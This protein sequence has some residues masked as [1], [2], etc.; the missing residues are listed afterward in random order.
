[1]A[2]HTLPIKVR[3]A[4]LD[5]YNHVNH[6]VYV[7]WFEA[8]RCEAME[9]VGCSLATLAAQHVQVV[10]ADLAVRYR[11]PA[12]ADDTVVVETWIVELGRVVARWRQRIIRTTPQG[13]VEVLCEA[14]VRAGACDDRGRPHRLPLPVAD[15]LR[16]LLVSGEPDR[17]ETTPT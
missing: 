8:G 14:E 3:F 11:L 17:D 16:S 15:A 5:P 13:R 10:V 1:M 9:S 7:S 4:E 2:P 6:S 12:V